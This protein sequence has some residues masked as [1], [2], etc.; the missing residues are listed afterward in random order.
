MKLLTTK[1]QT[2]ENSLL[3]TNNNLVA[4]KR[5]VRFTKRFLAIRVAVEY[6][7]LIKKGDNDIK[8]TRVTST[9]YKKYLVENHNLYN[10]NTAFSRSFR[11]VAA[12]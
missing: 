9:Q 1:I 8:I 2:L 3:M 4:R 7:V 5:V 10:P 11:K 12:L 6:Y